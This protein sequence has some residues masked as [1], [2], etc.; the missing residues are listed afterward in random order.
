MKTDKV[1][2][3]GRWMD[4]KHWRR[5]RTVRDKGWNDYALSRDSCPYT[6]GD[7]RRAWLDGWLTHALWDGSLDYNDYT[8]LDY[9]QDLMGAPG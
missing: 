1:M 6:R 5:L 4:K 3:D 2:V 7:F 8:E 9:Y